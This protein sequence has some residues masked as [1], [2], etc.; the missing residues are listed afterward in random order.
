MLGF[1]E[2]ATRWYEQ[3]R[4]LPLGA[5]VGLMKM[6]GRVRKFLDAVH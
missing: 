2:S 1:F 3:M 6:G 4:R 5:V